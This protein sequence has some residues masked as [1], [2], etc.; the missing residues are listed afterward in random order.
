MSSKVLSFPDRLT[1]R[2]V[3]LAL[4]AHGNLLSPAQLRARIKRPLELIKSEAQ[5]FAQRSPRFKLCRQEALLHLASIFAKYRPRGRV[6]RMFRCV[7]FACQRLATA[8]VDMHMTYSVWSWAE[9]VMD[10]VT[11]G[12]VRRVQVRL[13]RRAC[14][15]VRSAARA[16]AFVFDVC[17]SKRWM[18]FRLFFLHYSSCIKRAAAFILLVCRLLLPPALQAD[19]TLW[20]RQ[21]TET[22]FRCF[23]M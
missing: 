11:R 2:R 22:A 9:V 8:P 18:V 14:C 21:R 6:P 23:V 7:A 1:R 15:A 16:S 10:R 20:S 5:F 12:R 19:A 13:Q 4:I 17:C 3:S